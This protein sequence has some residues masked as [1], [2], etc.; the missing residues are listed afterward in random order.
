MT[1]LPPSSRRELFRETILLVGGCLLGIIL[2]GIVV[3]FT[4]V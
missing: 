2:L 3:Y 1:Y 4:T